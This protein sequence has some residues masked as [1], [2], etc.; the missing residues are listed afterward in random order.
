MSMTCI[1][2][3]GVFVGAIA[4]LAYCVIQIQ[5]E[6]DEQISQSLERAELAEEIAKQKAAE[7]AKYRRICDEVFGCEADL[8]YANSLLNEEKAAFDGE[9]TVSHE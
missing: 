9:D 8:E 5:S 2:A 6:A 7:A 1:V 4:Y 3:T